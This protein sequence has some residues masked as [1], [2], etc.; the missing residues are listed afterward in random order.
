[1][2]ARAVFWVALALAFLLLAIVA[3]RERKRVREIEH[4]LGG[5]PHVLIPAP[6][7][8]ALT[9]IL[10]VEAVGFLLAAIAAIYEA[11]T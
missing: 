5:L 6:V 4:P 10:R 11:F 9:N 2:L 8:T 3:W 7:A 1:M